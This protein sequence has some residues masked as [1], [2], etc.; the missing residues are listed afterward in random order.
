[1]SG[2]SEA[3]RTQMQVSLKKYLYFK[4]TTRHKEQTSLP[5]EHI[6]NTT[7]ISQRQTHQ[8]LNAHK[9]NHTNET[10]VRREEK[11]QGQQVNTIR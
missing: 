3:G 10:Q 8:N 9:T 1:M 11:A 6:E 2:L 5:C 7:R 4:D